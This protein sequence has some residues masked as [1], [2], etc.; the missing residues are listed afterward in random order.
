MKNM[1]TLIHLRPS[2]GVAY[3]ADT[4]DGFSESGSGDLVTIDPSQAE[5]LLFEIGIR[6]DKQ[7]TMEGGKWI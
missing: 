4:Q 6:V 5:S 3:A 7:I 2:V 1:K